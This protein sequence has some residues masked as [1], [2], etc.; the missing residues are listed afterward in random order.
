MGILGWLR[1][2]LVSFGLKLLYKFI[3]TKTAEV[4]QDLENKKEEKEFKK[5]LESGD[6]NEIAKAG[7]KII[8]SDKP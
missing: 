3:K 8:N 7:E 6:L 5:A 1:N 4:K 2:K